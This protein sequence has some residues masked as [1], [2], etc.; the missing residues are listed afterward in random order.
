MSNQI[1]NLILLRNNFPVTVFFL[2][3]GKE[4]TIGRS[5]DNAVILNDDRCSRYHAKI[6]FH[7]DHWFITD[8][9][10]R[11][12]TSVND[13]F[14]KTETEIKNG[15]KIKIGHDAL[16]FCFPSNSVDISAIPNDS[17]DNLD[18][19]RVPKVD[20]LKYSLAVSD[21]LLT[22]VNHLNNQRELTAFLDQARDENQFLRSLLNK[23]YQMIGSSPAMKEVGH[24]IER[25][26]QSKAT[27]LI[28]GESGVGKELV[29]R[30][31][32]FTSLRKKATLICLNCAAISESLLASE[33][34]GHEKG[35]FTGATERKIGKFEAANGGTL[36]LDEIAEMSPTLQAKF[37]RVL[38]GQPFERVG[39]NKPISVDVRVIAATNRRLEEEVAAGRFRHD[40]FFRLHVLEINVPPLRKRPED[41]ETL[42][43]FFLERYSQETNRRFDG[44]SP[45]AITTLLQYR[46]PGNV[47]EL[48]NVIERAVLLGNHSKIRPED[49]LLT[50]L[51]TT[52]NTNLLEQQRPLEVKTQT[53]QND[54]NSS[55]WP[56][57]IDEMEKKL[58]QQTLDYF[59]WNKSNS[60]KTLGIERTTLDRK[61]ARYKIQRND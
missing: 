39:G 58:I 4:T 38:E 9:A 22:A 56:Q 17:A 57:T 18:D 55:F 27:V 59:H 23:E 14:I 47:R 6:H 48:K 44:F 61:I 53:P 21:T 11:N 54:S 43:H 52:G 19:S 13:I 33:L 30:A 45:E 41:I 16:V 20:P 36:F 28:R 7:D 49:I 40:L 10:S 26:A 3:S 25:A 60:A 35:A 32:H 8:L 34:F 2:T 1:A 42:A 50:T 29:A 24:L 37:L 15:D 31:V 51:Q 12:G 5:T 46:W